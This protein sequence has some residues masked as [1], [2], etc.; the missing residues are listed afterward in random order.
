MDKLLLPRSDGNYVF[1]GWLQSLKSKEEIFCDD[2][3]LG[4]LAAILQ[5]EFPEDLPIDAQK[6]KNGV[7]VKLDAPI[8]LSDLFSKVS[9]YVFAQVTKHIAQLGITKD[10]LVLVCAYKYFLEEADEQPEFFRQRTV[11][12]KQ[13][14]QIVEKADKILKVIL[15]QENQVDLRPVKV[16]IEGF[17]KRQTDT[18]KSVHNMELVK[19]SSPSALYELFIKNIQK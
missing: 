18:E 12:F 19:S 16:E 14:S 6:F 10:Q 1:Y 2:I 7:D 8:K 9:Q 17:L 3:V 11:T 5:K 4:E 13:A 15:L